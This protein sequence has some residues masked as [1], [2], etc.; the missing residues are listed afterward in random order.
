MSLDMGP[1][2]LLAWFLRERRK[3]VALEYLDVAQSE[4]IAYLS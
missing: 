4:D 1:V 3:A 2:P